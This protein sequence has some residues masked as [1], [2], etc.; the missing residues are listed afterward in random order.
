MAIDTWPEEVKIVA[1]WHGNSDR[2][3][4]GLQRCVSRD[5]GED[6]GSKTV[7]NK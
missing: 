6:Q 3:I 1:V 4:T 7:T 5:E 2:I